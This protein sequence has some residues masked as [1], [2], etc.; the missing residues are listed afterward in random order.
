MYREAEHRSR[1]V[2]SSIRVESVAGYEPGTTRVARMCVA[3][4]TFGQ[5]KNLIISVEFKIDIIEFI[6]KRLGGDS[7][8]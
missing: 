8:E 4:A 6:L 5:S 1:T 2:E 7:V 3:Q